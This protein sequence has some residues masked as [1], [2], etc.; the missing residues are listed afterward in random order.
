MP[1][2]RRVH[3]R[4]WGDQ[5][6]RELSA[7][8]PNAQTLWLYLLT[9]PH[10][11]VVPGL[12]HVGEAALAEGLGWPVKGLREAFHEIAQKG[13]A[14][15]DWGVRVLFLPNAVRCNPPESPNVVKAWRKAFDELPECDLKIEAFHDIKGFLEGFAEAFREAF[16]EALP[17]AIAK[18]SRSPV[19]SDLTPLRESGAGAGAGA[20]AGSPPTP[21]RGKDWIDLLNQL[22]GRAFEPGEPYLR[23]IR[24]RIKSGRTVAEAEVVIRD[25]MA[26]WADDAKT[27]EW[28]RPETL[29]GAKFGTYL[30][31]AQK[32]AAGRTYGLDLTE[33]YPARAR[34]GLGAGSESTSP[35]RESP[36][37]AHS[38]EIGRKMARARD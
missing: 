19:E 11:G 13:M 28:L 9:G 10:T 8:P 4:L 26:K 36:E 20:G 34:N 24:A 3:I 16:R 14:R 30:A 6:F 15:A 7:P 5:K 1:R 21:P 17:E 12:S 2:Y 32:P 27:R 29:F 18:P 25:R 22:T 35:T 31:L 23:L 37:A 33:N 38:P